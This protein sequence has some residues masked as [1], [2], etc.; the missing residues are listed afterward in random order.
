MIQTHNIPGKIYSDCSFVLTVTQGNFDHA[1]LITSKLKYYCH[2]ERLMLARA[3][4][5][6][7]QGRRQL[8]FTIK[9]FL[10]STY[11]RQTRTQFS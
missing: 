10:D 8:E 2:S 9:L 4:Y 7:L 11:P 5:M 3:L 1:Q 6:Y